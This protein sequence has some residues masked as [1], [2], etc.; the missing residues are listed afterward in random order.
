MIRLTHLT[1]KA[2]LALTLTAFAG[3]TACSLTP[4]KSMMNV[5]VGETFELK[6]PVKIKADQARTFI[7]F[8]KVTTKSGFDRYDQHCRIEMTDLAEKERTIQPDT[9]KITK[10]RIGSEQVAMNDQAAMMFASADKASMQSLVWFSATMGGRIPA[11][12]MDFVT[13]HLS[14]QKQ[15]DVYA[16]TCAGSLSNGD[17]LDAPRSYRPQRDQMNKILGSIGEVK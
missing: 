9:F 14:S 13:L 15:A 6:Q 11:P 12:T 5:Q 3:L 16:L 7:Q 1:Q 17:P 10:V 4:P 2:T 8:G